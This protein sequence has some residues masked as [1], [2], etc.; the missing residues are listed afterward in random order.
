MPEPNF[1]WLPRAIEAAAITLLALLCALSLRTIVLGDSANSR[2]ATAYSLVHYGSWLIDDTPGHQNPFEPGTVDK[3]ER[4]G[5]RLS[6]KPP[7]LP[8]MMAAEYWLIFHTTGWRLDVREE[9]RT[10]VRIM[11]VTL[12]ILPLIV[13]IGAFSACLGLLGVG[14]WMR[15]YLVA[16]LA[17]GTELA[18]FGG[19]INNHT[20]AAAALAVAAWCALGPLA[21]T[22][23]PTPWRMLGYGVAGGL[24]FTL[25]L[26]ETIYVAALGIALLW[27][28]PSQAILW[29]GIGIGIPVGVHFVAMLISTGS[30]L[31][32]QMHPD[33]YLYESAYWRNPGGV[34]ALHEPKGTYLFHMTFGRYGT[35]LLFPTLALGLVGGAVALL[36]RPRGLV[37]WLAIASLGCFAVLTAYYVFKTNNYGGAAY[38]FRWHMASAPVL[39]IAALPF[40]Q[41]LWRPLWAAPLLLLLGVSMFSAWECYQNPWA[42]DVEWTARWIFGPGI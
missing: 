3:V 15:A 27:R 29:G 31:P 33:W 20:P 28:Y 36:R 37:A 41:R 13:G 17:L 39:L 40:L 2:L 8:L 30:I 9:A 23:A 21:G 11:V 14:A 22:R 18:G 26:P 12:M 10:I 24:V 34:D 6:T 4:E 1:P 42:K 35:F 32:V 25:D 7:V 38:G 5:H 19:H 16:A